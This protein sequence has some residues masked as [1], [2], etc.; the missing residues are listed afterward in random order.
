MPCLKSPLWNKSGAGTQQPPRPCLDPLPLRQA[1]TAP[2]H[3]LSSCQ[4]RHKQKSQRPSLLNGRHNRTRSAPCTMSAPRPQKLEHAHLY[5]NYRFNPMK[6]VNKDRIRE[7]K[8]QA[9]EQERAGCRTTRDA[10]HQYPLPTASTST[11]QAP[12][13]AQIVL[14]N[15]LSTRLIRVLAVSW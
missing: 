3:P 15:C 6:R 8:R 5:P 12:Q 1:P 9:K 10:L 11:P 2:P 4:S 13:V 14:Q 7:E